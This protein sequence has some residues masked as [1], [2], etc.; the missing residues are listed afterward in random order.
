MWLHE[1]MYFLVKDYVC[2]RLKDWWYWK[3]DIPHFPASNF[4]RISSFWFGSLAG[5]K[6]TYASPIGNFHIMPI[7][8]ASCEGFQIPTIPLWSFYH[9]QPHHPMLA[10]LGSIVESETGLDGRDHED[11]L[12]PI[13]LLWTGTPFTIQVAQRPIHPG[14]EHFKEWGSHNFSGQPLL[15]SHHLHSKEFLPYI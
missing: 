8:N 10:S 3:M 7:L 6:A 1:P 4:Y 14:P 9:A 5:R 2:W 12:V 13:P 11:V 15:V